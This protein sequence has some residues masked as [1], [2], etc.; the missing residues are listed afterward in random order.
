MHTA[1]ALWACCK[2]L[3]GTGWASFLLQPCSLS[4]SGLQQPPLYTL[5]QELISENT[6]LRDKNRHLRNETHTFKTRKTVHQN[7][8]RQLRLQTENMFA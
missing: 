3:F 2:K 5:Q 6:Y 8:L 7:K 4:A 1:A